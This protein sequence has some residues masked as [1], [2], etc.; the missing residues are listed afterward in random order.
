M[1]M[2]YLSLGFGG[3]AALEALDIN[4]GI[5]NMRNV[6]NTNHSFNSFSYCNLSL[7]LKVAAS[8]VTSDTTCRTLNCNKR[9]KCNKEIIR[10]GEN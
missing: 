3:A 1:G 7:K 9:P 5:Y 6:L 8:A 4:R 2:G 10:L